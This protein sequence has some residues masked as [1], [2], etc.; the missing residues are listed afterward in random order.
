MENLASVGMVELN[1][2]ELMMVDGGGWREFGQAFRASITLGLLA[3]L[4]FA[5][6]HIVEAGRMVQWA[7]GEIETASANAY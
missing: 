4:S 5:T 2:E 1:E 7:W 3:P 6:G